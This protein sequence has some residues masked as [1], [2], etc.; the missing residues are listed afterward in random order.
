M[1]QNTLICVSLWVVSKWKSKRTK[2][3]VLWFF[4]FHD[5]IT[6]SES[7]IT[8]VQQQGEQN[9]LFCSHV[10]CKVPGCW[11]WLAAVQHMISNH[12]SSM[13]EKGWVR[14]PLRLFMLVFFYVLYVES[15]LWLCAAV[16]ASVFFALITLSFPVWHIIK[17]WGDIC[18]SGGLLRAKNVLRNGTGAFLASSV[19]RRP[20]EEGWKGKASP[21]LPQITQ[22]IPNERETMAPLPTGCRTKPGQIQHCC[23]VVALWQLIH[24][25]Q[26]HL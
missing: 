14:L 13:F 23:S 24:T 26:W 16:C 4:T 25:F 17:L 11:L 19:A 20:F 15:I 3:T 8:S 12:I 18:S 9:S 6:Y 1:C 5:K 10:W 21:W 7:F 22:C 2:G